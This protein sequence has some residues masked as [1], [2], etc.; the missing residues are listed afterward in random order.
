MDASAVTQTLKPGKLFIGGKPSECASGKKIDVMNP[1]TGELLTTVE[2][3]E[4]ADVDRPSRPRARH[5]S[6]VPGRK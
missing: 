5:S 6:P 4:A 3:G 2:R 1:A